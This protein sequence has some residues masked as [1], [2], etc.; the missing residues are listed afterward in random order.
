MAERKWVLVTGAASGI[1]KTIA[2]YLA[3][4]D[5]QGITG[6]AINVCGGTIFY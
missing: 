2:L 1:G 6:Q 3:S 5:A 4:E